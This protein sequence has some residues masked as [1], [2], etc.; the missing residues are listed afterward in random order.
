M[1]RQD[2][3]D[4]LG[5]AL[6]TVSRGFTRLQDDGV[7]VVLGRS[8]EVVDVAELRRLAHGCEAAVLAAQAR[9]R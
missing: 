3:A 9:Q 5:L 4:F 6:E 8:V 2:I 1:G 7:I